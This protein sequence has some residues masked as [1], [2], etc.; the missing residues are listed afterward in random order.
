[1]ME[2]KLTD[3]PF[4]AEQHK[5]FVI[6]LVADGIFE[7]QLD[8][9][10]YAAAY[11][12]KHNIEVLRQGVQRAEMAMITHLDRKTLDSLLAALAATNAANITKSSP[13]LLAELSYYAS[14]G[15]ERLKGEIGAYSSDEAYE[16]LLT[17]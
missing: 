16:F 7:K 17:Q 8:A 15:T 13:E 3:R 14:A 4:I 1:M 6:K 9:W 11:A 12:L 2:V 5:A 10:A